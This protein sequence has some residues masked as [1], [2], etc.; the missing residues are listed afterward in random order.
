MSHVL[1][2]EKF[3]PKVTPKLFNLSIQFRYPIFLDLFNSIPIL[4]HYQSYYSNISVDK[5]ASLRF[6]IQYLSSSTKMKTNTEMAMMFSNLNPPVPPCTIIWVTKTFSCEN[7]TFVKCTISIFFPTTALMQAPPF[8]STSL[9]NINE[10]DKFNQKT[11]S[12]PRWSIL[13]ICHGHHGRCPWR[14]N[15]P[16]GE[17]TYC[18]L[19]RFST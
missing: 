14:K 4:S 18:Y 6:C 15:L 5:S 12:I 11:F 2:V 19:K 16:C 9:S 8:A 1:Y 17:M 7:K 3:G 10:F 13:D